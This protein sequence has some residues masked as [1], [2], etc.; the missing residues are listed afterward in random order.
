MKIICSVCCRMNKV[1]KISNA[2]AAPQ[3]QRAWFAKHYSDWLS[4]KDSFSFPNF[5]YA[6]HIEVGFAEYIEK[7]GYNIKLIRPLLDDEH[8]V[9]YISE[10]EY[11]M[12]RLRVSNED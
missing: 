4:N 5:F 11:V 7:L 9:V 12:E 1:C 2:Y 8:L 10:E 6:T 3:W